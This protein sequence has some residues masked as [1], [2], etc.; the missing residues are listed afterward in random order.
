VRDALR[1]DKDLRDEYGAVKKR[2]GLQATNIDDYG[3]A[4]NGVVLKILKA[5]GLTD[6]DVASIA[7]NQIPTDDELPR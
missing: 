4:K 7:A 3:R 1:A 5:A 6:K 2:V